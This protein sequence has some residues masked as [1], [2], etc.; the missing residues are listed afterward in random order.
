MQKKV[1]LFGPNHT[2]EVW[3]QFSWTELSVGHYFLD[4]LLSDAVGGK[5][6]KSV[7][8]LWYTFFFEQDVHLPI[9]PSIL[10][11]S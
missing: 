5:H 11:D 2:V 3:Q 10:T 4:W 1:L 6:F 8:N 7:K 9:Y